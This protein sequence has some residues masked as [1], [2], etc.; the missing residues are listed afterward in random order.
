[1]PGGSGWGG[2]GSSQFQGGGG[3]G[4][5]A[6]GNASPSNIDPP[7]AEGGDSFVNTAI[8]N[9]TIIEGDPGIAGGSIGWRHFEDENGVTGTPPLYFSRPV[10]DGLVVVGNAAGLEQKLTANCQ[11]DADG[12]GMS[13]Y[14]EELSGT[15]PANSDSDND[16]ISDGD[17][18][19]SG[20]N[21]LDPADGIPDTDDDGSSDDIDNCPLIAN[22]DQAD[23]DADG[24]GDVCD[25]CPA[26]ANTD[27]ADADGDGIGDVC[28]N[29]PA[30]ANADQVDVDGDDI[31]D[32][33]D[34]QVCV[35]RTTNW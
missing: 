15:D 21:P 19:Y 20:M 2:G 9:G 16:G 31:G 17:E 32:A 14:Q 4:G 5:Y 18:F 8:R 26:D 11:S 29:C 27:Q 3:G 23:T 25:N 22:A 28:D 33:C 12:D 34:L 7:G 13:D 10:Y 24:F 6:G 35:R 30:D 1:M